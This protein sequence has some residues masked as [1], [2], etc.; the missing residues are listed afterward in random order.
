MVKLI[1][2]SATQKLITLT[3]FLDSKTRK[4]LYEAGSVNVQITWK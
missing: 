4:I 2:T 1:F 3:I